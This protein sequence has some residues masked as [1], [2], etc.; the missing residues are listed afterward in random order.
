M[1]QV[2]LSP[3]D[4]ATFEFAGELLVS[5][6]GNDADGRTGGRW[7]DLSVYR[8][9]SGKLAICVTFRTAAVTE[10]EHC[11]VELADDLAEV[12]TLLSLY[13]PKGHI[14]LEAGSDRNRVI[15]AVVRSYDLQVLEALDQLQS[16]SAPALPDA[17]APGKP[18]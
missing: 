18:R 4:A 13:D 3:T 11:Y 6:A 14:V 17:D 16:L 5:I 10:V 8:T 9:D 15:D 2:L 1:Q 12:D 7:H